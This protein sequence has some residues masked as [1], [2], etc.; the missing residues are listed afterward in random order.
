VT[1]GVGVGVVLEEGGWRWV[2]GGNDGDLLWVKGWVGFL[3]MHFVIT[4]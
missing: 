2:D 1:G 3:G 4:D